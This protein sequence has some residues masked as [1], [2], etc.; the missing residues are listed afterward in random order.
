MVAEEDSIF[1]A[2]KFAG[3]EQTTGATVVTVSVEEYDPFVPE[4]VARTLTS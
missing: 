4:Q 2:V 3:T 1:V